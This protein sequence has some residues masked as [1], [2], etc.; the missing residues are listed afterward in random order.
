MVEYD[1]SDITFKS[2]MSTGKDKSSVQA[3]KKFKQFPL[4]GNS[5]CCCLFSNYEFSAT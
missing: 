3:G 2:Y 1:Q 4:S 5:D